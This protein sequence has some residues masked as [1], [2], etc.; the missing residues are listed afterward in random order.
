MWNLVSAVN[1]LVREESD[2]LPTSG[3]PDNHSKRK[4]LDKVP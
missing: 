1:N 3:K 2:V 4:V